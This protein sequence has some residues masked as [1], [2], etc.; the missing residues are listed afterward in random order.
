[1]YIFDENRRVTYSMR[2]EWRAGESYCGIKGPLWKQRFATI[3][4]KTFEQSLAGCAC[5]GIAAEHTL[6]KPI[7]IACT[8][9]ITLF[10]RFPSRHLFIRGDAIDTYHFCVRPMKIY[11]LYVLL[12]LYIFYFIFTFLIICE[13]FSSGNNA[14]A[15]YKFKLAVYTYRSHSAIIN[16]ILNCDDS[17]LMYQL[18]YESLVLQKL[19]IEISMC[20][21]VCDVWSIII[22]ECT[23][24][25][26]IG[27]S[28][29]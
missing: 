12:P 20:V 2:G 22:N 5:G 1:M 28:R 14:P 6:G 11:F 26:L 19:Q 25:W 7:H 10:S 21:C 4:S 18:K 9:S 16:N 13:H 17:R 27:L 29:E 24:D 8:R 15:R 23:N 3:Y